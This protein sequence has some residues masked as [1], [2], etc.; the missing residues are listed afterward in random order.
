M[1][2]FMSILIFVGV[3]LQFVGFKS[4]NSL[5]Y[6]EN[7]LFVYLILELPK[8]FIQYFLLIRRIYKLNSCL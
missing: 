5:K 3:N 1:Q 6:F 4:R 7:K 8:V 2:V